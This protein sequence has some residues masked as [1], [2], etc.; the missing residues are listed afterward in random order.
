[1][2]KYFRPLFSVSPFLESFVGGCNRSYNEK[3]MYVVVVSLP[4][5]CLIYNCIGSFGTVGCNRTFVKW[6]MWAMFVNVL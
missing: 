4:E 1:M 5:N 6:N 2:Q 3:G